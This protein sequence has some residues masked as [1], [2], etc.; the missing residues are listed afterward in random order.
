[1]L[2]QFLHS[3]HQGQQYKRLPW[4]FERKEKKTPMFFEDRLRSRA[5]ELHSLQLM[6]NPPM[7]FTYYLEKSSPP[8]LDFIMLQGKY[9]QGPLMGSCYYIVAI[10]N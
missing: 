7:H 1:M 9:L 2:K 10:R 4:D 8:A 3:K 5:S 6:A